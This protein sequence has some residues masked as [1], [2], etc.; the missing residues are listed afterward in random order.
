MRTE[1]PSKTS[2]IREIAPGAGS[3]SLCPT[4][5]RS[6]FSGGAASRGLCVKTLLTDKQLFNLVYKMQKGTNEA[7]HSIT[8]WPQ[9]TNIAPLRTFYLFYCWRTP[10]GVGLCEDSV[11][12]LLVNQSLYWSFQARHKCHAA[13]HQDEF[14]SRPQLVGTELL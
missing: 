1:S 11:T 13:W 10:F 4:P 8:F 14:S 12:I 9:K 2:F 7:G 6:D 3:P 5:R